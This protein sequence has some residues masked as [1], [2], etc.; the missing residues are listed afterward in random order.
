MKTLS[1]AISDVEY[2]KFGIPCERLN[3]TKIN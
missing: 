1:V 3:F 2:G